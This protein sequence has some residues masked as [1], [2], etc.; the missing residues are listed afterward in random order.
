M[1]VVPAPEI[2]DAGVE[3]ADERRGARDLLLARGDCEAT[4]AQKLV[5][6]LTHEIGERAAVSRRKRLERSQ[7]L[8]GEL[9]LGP[10]HGDIMIAKTS[11]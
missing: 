8:V 6:R 9:N 11:T 10:D 2:A 4:L 1:V 7:L 5:D 3:R